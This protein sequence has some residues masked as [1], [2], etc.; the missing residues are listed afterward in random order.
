MPS[1][2]PG[3]LVWDSSLVPVC[4]TPSQGKGVGIAVFLGLFR[5]FQF[6]AIAV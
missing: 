6:F 3:V 1:T 2:T 5:E 4:L